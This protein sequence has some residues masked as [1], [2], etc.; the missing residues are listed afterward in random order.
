M[1]MTQPYETI[2]IWKDKHVDSIHFSYEKKKM[3]IYLLI[4]YIRASN[5]T[6]FI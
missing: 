3:K 5:E 6:D 2:K 4:I 1:M